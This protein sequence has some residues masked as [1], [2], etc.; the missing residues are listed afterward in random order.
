M[1]TVHVKSH[2][3][4]VAL[5]MRV[6]KVRRPR[7]PAAASRLVL[8]LIARSPRPKCPA[9]ALSDGQSCMKMPVL[10]LGGVADTLRV[11]YPQVEAGRLVACV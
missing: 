6:F 1:S 2:V 9:P 8:V 11:T 10:E 7:G 4:S 5:V 3:V